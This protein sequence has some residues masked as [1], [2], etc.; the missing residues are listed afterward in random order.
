MIQPIP[1]A[2]PPGDASERRPGYRPKRRIPEGFQEELLKKLRAAPCKTP[3]WTYTY[4][5]GGTDDR[6]R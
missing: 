2:Q 5:E 3:T 6:D 4:P 1:P